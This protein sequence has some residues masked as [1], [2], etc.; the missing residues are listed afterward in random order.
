MELESRKQTFLHMPPEL[1]ETIV[2]S[3]VLSIPDV[4]R[5]SRVC[6]LL[7]E[8]VS[9]QWGMLAKNRYTY[10]VNLR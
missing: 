9:R 5:L 7:Y 2:L 8:T 6:R 1:L 3:P 10:V 4:F